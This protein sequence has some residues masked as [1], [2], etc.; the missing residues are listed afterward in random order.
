MVMLPR[1]NARWPAIAAGIFCLYAVVLL[2]NAFAA[3]GQLRVAA[4]A[5]MVVEGQRC[6]AALGEYASR[7]RLAAQSLAS[8]HELRTYLVNKALGMSPLYGLNANLAA[9]EQRFR[10]GIERDNAAM[11]PRFSRILY[12]DAQGLVLADTARG[13]GLPALPR[14]QD[15]SAMSID[16][17]LRVLVTVA[18]VMFKEGDAGAVITLSDIGQLYQS[19]IQGV[20][21][22]SYHE[23]LL[24]RDGREILPPS[25]RPV[26][27]PQ[28]TQ[29][30][31]HQSAGVPTPVT[32][33]AGGADQ[34]LSMV[35]AV[36]V[37]T[38]VPGLDVALVSSV[39][40]D[41]VYGHLSSPLYLYSLSAFPVLVLLALWQLQRVQGHARVLER[42]AVLSSQ[43][44][45]V[46]TYRNEALKQE[47]A[48]R[49]LAEA[50]LQRHRDHLEDMV[51]R[52]TAELNRLFH[53]L[54]DLYF[55]VAREGTILEYR[56]G[57]D[58]DMYLRP[59][60]FMSRKVQDVLPDE[61]A[62][63]FTAA[64]AE[65]N[66]GAEQCVIEYSLPMAR[67]PQ[68]YEARL[69]TLDE[70]QLV[71]VVRNVT[72]R[73][74]NEQAM[75]INRREAERLSRVKSELLAN[76]S[77][78]IRTPLNAVLGLAQIGARERNGPAGNDKFQGILDAGRHLLGI[79]DDILDFSK[80]EAGKLSIESQPF[81]L[82]AMVRAVMALAAGRSEAKQ[83]PMVVDLA[84]DLPE[85]V[86]GDALRLKQVLVNL[87]SNAV[88]FTDHGQVSLKV[89][90]SEGWGHFEVADTGIGMPPDLLARLFQPF[91]QAD[92]STT[93][94]FG[95]TGLGLSISHNLA[96]LM[97]G[98]IA[99][100]ST[101]GEGSTF[102]LSLPLPRAVAGSNAP[103]PA[104]FGQHR[105]RGISL[106]AAE[107]NEVNR[108]ILQAQLQSEGAVVAF[109]KNGREAVAMVS[110]YPGGHDAVLMDVQMP[111]MDGLE[112][113]RH[114]RL[115][116]P[117][118][119]IIGLTAR[120]LTDERERCLAAGM[121]DHVAKPVDLDLLVACLLRHVP[122]KA[123]L[124]A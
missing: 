78:E 18:P 73:K 2:W 101:Q 123:N 65:L 57:R 14:V 24:S 114:L 45:D 102:T 68:S 4:D 11:G 25:G 48:Q 23:A 46:L 83:L 17:A 120:A 113:T 82:P 79:V 3:Q 36:A 98:H 85:W 1:I 34:R 100:T 110:A 26:F 104:P 117:S 5:R 77:H 16:P 9:V 108:M 33:L 74:L 50:E 87:L 54:P 21:Q 97:G 15:G 44:R 69:L 10:E 22:G 89:W 64:L 43:H 106:L 39:A 38:P 52:R 35:E 92:G 84:P 90:L 119:P 47:I 88:K 95:G 121:V 32:Q 93:R 56:A 13:L 75:E 124:P 60:Q 107:D 29:N 49:E 103:A 12:R 63:K 96:V 58:A 115:L 122:G 27:S 53:A 80:L 59:E 7:Q 28:V 41:E 72:E 8:T 55:R 42:D 20:A 70:A 94:R 6:A 112:A 37:T 91:E 118:L 40:R 86:V 111:E 109:A 66:A 51:Q 30:L 67:G 81:R 62:R 19:L 105:L 99:V 31:M 116:A 61:V 71:I 76:M